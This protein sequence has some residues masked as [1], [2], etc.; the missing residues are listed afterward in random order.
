M[1]RKLQFKI[2]AIMASVLLA[3]F[4]VVFVTLN[5]RMQIGSFQKM[6]SWL[7][8]VADFDGVMPATS[9]SEANA[10][11]LYAKLDHENNITEANIEKIHNLTMEGL[12]AITTATLQQNKQS[13]TIDDYQF[14]I[15]DKAYGKIIIYTGRGATVELLSDLVTNSLVIAGISCIVLLVIS[16]LL[17]R[18]AVRP[19]KDAFEKQRQFI[20][21]AGHEL[22]T[23][24]TV[25]MTNMDILK[26]DIGENTEIAFVEDQAGRMNTLI[27]D[28]LSL[29]KTDEGAQAVRHAEFDLSSAVRNTVLGFESAAFEA[30]RKMSYDIQEN[31]RY[32]GDELQIRNVVSIFTDNAVKHSNSGGEIKIHLKRDGA[33]IK[34]SFYNTGAGVKEAERERIFERFYRSDESRSRE[35]GGYGLG[36]AIAKSVIQQHGGKIH[37]DG[38]AGEWVRFTVRL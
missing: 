18:W 22:K 4:V 6:E 3:V 28:M 13:G 16:V 30:G 29:A 5:I 20:S 23:P 32:T 25:I 9:E 38:M 2:A 11:E 15:A 26:N 1:I 31:I 37:V 10:P 21:D 7:Q 19:V 33:K 34:L 17:A 36:L 12:Q 14:Y 35:T 24:L 27:H 8:M